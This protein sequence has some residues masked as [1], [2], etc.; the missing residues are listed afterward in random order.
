MN[1]GLAVISDVPKTMVY[2]LAKFI[3]KEQAVIPQRIIDKAPSAELKHGQTDQDDL[4]PYAILDQ[5]LK[6]YVED[7]KGVDELAGEG[8]D[9]GLVIDIINRVHRNEYK[10]H[11]AAPGLKVTSK[12]F[13][14]G[15]RYPLAQRFT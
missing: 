10:R 2:E 5:V 11:Q 7:A 13:G 8:I 6:G 14:Y 1:G 4:P 15:R 12:A 9:R 3:N